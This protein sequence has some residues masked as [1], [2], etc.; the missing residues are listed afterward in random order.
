VADYP[1]PLDQ[2]LT[3]G[4]PAYPRGD[5]DDYSALGLSP[6]H[7]PDLIRMATDR[8]LNEADGDSAEVWAPVH[9]WRAL[10]QFRSAEAVGP[11]LELIEP[12]AD[13]DDDWCL[14]D[15]PVVLG[16]IGPQALPALTDYLADRGR[17]RWGRIAAGTALAE[18][19]KRHPEARQACVAV[20]TGQLEKGLAKDH[21]LNGFLVANL[22]N[23]EAT[24]AAP[25]IEKAF[26]A[27]VVDPSIAGDWPL[28]AWRL[29]VPGAQPPR[30]VPP[31]RPARG[32]PGP[33]VAGQ[34][35]TGRA[36]ARRKKRKEAKEAKK[37]N[38]KRR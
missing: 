17:S 26:A 37:R 23:L 3:R 12:A 20:L 34:S 6:E 32:L 15:L 19:G 30:A 14:Q 5:F 2:L 21:D 24:E 29:K 8:A 10:A 13:R 27:G 38:R 28:V 11:L 1:P 25:V 22:L 9:A 7:V 4:E 31:P 36:E 35:F 33:V 18:M 16:M